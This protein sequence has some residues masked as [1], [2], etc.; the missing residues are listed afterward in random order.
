MHPEN[1]I[2]WSFLKGYFSALG[3]DSASEHYF[4]SH[5]EFFYC[6]EGFFGAA[7]YNR[8]VLIKESM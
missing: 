5:F 7:H 1:G 4:A 2:L 6:T 8:A 3:L